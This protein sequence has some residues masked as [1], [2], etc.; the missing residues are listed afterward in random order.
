MNE[1][2]RNP[3]ATSEAALATN[4]LAPPSA[5]SA[6]DGAVEYGSFLRRLG[7]LLLDFLILSPVLAITYVGIQYSKM[8]YAWYFIPGNLLSLFYWVWL[9]QKYGG[10]PGKRILGMRIALVDGGKVTLNA[11]LLRYSVLGIM[12]VI[13][14]YALLVGTRNISDEAYYSMGYLEKS[15]AMANAAPSY[16]PWLGRLSAVW[17][18]AVG[19]SI[20]CTNRRRA[21]HDFIAGTVVI[22]ERQ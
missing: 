2:R 3:Y 4:D 18:L 13:Q 16:Y 14:Q 11:A 5:I 12:T 21:L 19:V 1:A 6:L 22:R 9:V 10:T 7:A 8:F 15:L 20:L 17:M